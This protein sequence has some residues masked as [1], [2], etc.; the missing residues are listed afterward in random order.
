MHSDEYFDE[1]VAATY[2]DDVDALNPETVEPVVDFL[3]E[4]ASGGRA[5]EFGIETGRI[6]L[7]LVMKGVEVHGIDLSK[8]MLTKLT[9]KTGSELNLMA[10]I[11]NLELK[12]R[13]G[14]WKKEPFTRTSRYH[15]SVWE[16]PRD[17]PI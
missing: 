16:K 5:L 1:R 6:A 9:E 13:W 3:A 12:A 14:G 2:D 10:R 11:A 17:G 7:P 8:A 4:L 15:V